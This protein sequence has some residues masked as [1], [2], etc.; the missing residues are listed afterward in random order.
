LI[1]VDHLKI[2]Q[3]GA[4]TTLVNAVWNPFPFGSGN[5]VATLATAVFTGNAWSVSQGTIV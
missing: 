2:S 3:S 1:E 4:A 5:F